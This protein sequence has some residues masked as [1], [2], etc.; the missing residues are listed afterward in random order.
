MWW[1][2]VWLMREDMHK[3]IVERPRHKPRA[4]SK[5]RGRVADDMPSHRSMASD[6][7]RND[8][9]KGQTDLLGP[10]R[11]YLRKQVGRPWNDVYSEL[12]TKRGGFLGRHLRQHARDF[13]WIDVELDPK[14]RP[15][16]RRRSWP[17]FEPKRGDLF[18][19]PV[20]GLLRLCH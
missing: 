3:V 8:H 11:R 17:Y 13:V 4:A 5:G 14:G 12:S 16:R 1:N 19:D 10:L 20:T 2:G 18:V 9:Q 6:Y 15:K 7:Q